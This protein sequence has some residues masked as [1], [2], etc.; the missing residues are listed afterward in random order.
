MQ[1]L[2]LVSIL[3]FICMKSLKI[4]RLILLQTDT[5]LLFISRRIRLLFQNSILKKALF[6][7]G[8][9]VIKFVNIMLVFKTNFSFI[10]LAREQVCGCCISCSKR[11]SIK[12]LYHFKR[13]EL[14]LASSG[15][16]LTD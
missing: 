11:R 14:V 8:D 13:F 5:V 4:L 10:L 1:N 16:E 2:S 7:G 6:P 9:R 12:K 3:R 15:S